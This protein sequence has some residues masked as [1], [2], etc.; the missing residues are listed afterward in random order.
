MVA[1]E[2]GHVTG[3]RHFHVYIR[4]TKRVTVNEFNFDMCGLHPH[5]ST[6]KR[7]GSRSIEPMIKYLT[8]EDKEPLCTFDYKEELVEGSDDSK[9]PNWERYLSERLTQNQVIARLHEEG[10]AS[11]FAN[12]FSNWI[13]YIKKMFPTEPKAE[14]I[15]PYTQGDF[16]L[17]EELAMWK[18]CY[19]QGWLENLRRY[20]E[21]SRP[22]SLILIGPSR[23]G[24]TEWARSLGK[25]MYFNNLLN[26]DDWD[27]T[28]DYIILDDFSSDI[29]KF[30]PSWKCFFGGQKQFTLTDKYRGKR[31][32]KWGKPMIWLSNEDLYKNLNIEHLNFLKKIVHVLFYKINYIK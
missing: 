19:F 28:A 20:G 17:P 16:K 27:D 26:M 14:Y 32:V 15:S 22:Q 24:K 8:K 4:F 31:T 1:E 3:R 12:H 10:F 29:T 18:L 13:A 30:L 5:I 7:N 9:E 25:H 6:V 11:R 2:V 23:S 21:W